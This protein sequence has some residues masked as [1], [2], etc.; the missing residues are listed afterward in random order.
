MCCLCHSQTIDT[1]TSRYWGLCMFWCVALSRCLKTHVL[2]KRGWKH[3][4]TS[5]LQN[6]QPTLHTR[7]G[8]GAMHRMCLKP[9]WAPP[10]PRVGNQYQREGKEGQSQ[11]HTNPARF[12]K[13][14]NHAGQKGCTP[15]QVSTGLF[16][17]TPFANPKEAAS[18]VRIALPTKNSVLPRNTT[19]TLLQGCFLK[20][21]KETTYWNLRV[22]QQQ[23]GQSAL[24]PPAQLLPPGLAV[25]CPITQLS[26]PKPVS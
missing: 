1:K 2:N 6:A 16:A 25:G 18:G 19:A 20:Q 15:G 23:D 17:D 26:L 11:E 3:K 4:T 21:M 22:L 13:L 9:Q 10:H 5:R 7:Q 8:K 12:A 14:K 24:G